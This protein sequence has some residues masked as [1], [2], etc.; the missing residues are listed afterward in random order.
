MPYSPREIARSCDV[1]EITAYRWI[2]SGKLPYT[3]TGRRI[4]V[5]DAD[6]RAFLLSR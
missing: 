3:R 1:A 6:L 5:D 2:R 4:R